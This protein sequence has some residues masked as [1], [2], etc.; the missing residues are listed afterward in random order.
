MLGC[1]TFSV[2]EILLFETFL[3][4][5]SIKAIKADDYDGSKESG[6]S[7]SSNTEPD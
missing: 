5:L 7:F 1:Y 2:S 6:M 3:Q 4:G